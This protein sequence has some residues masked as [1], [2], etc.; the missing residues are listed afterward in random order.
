MFLVVYGWVLVVSSTGHRHGT[1]PRPVTRFG[2]LLGVCFPV[3]HADRRGRAA[4]RG[5]SAAQFAFGVPGVVIGAIAWLALPV[6]PLVL[7]RRV[8]GKAYRTPIAHK[9]GMS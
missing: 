3:G 5:G 1:L 8:F 9:E 2:L 7:A 6:W 4:V